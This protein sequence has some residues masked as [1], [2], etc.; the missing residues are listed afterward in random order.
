MCRAMTV[1]CA[2]P[3]RERL[4]ALKRASVSVNWELVG[5]AS[6]PEELLHQVAEWLPDVVV[7][8]A[9]LGEDS[10]GLVRQALPRA[11]IVAIGVGPM[12]GADV[13]ARSEQ[14]VRP[15]IVGLPRPGGPVG[16]SPSA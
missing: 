15:A 3:G 14:E 10:A 1:L 11:R 13:V 4:S 9:G 8:D 12:A 6:S 16:G 7:I 5:G 2:A